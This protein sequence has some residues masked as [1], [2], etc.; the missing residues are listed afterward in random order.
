M[1]HDRAHVD[2]ASRTLL[3]HDAR[4]FLGYQKAGGQVG[5]NHLLPFLACQLQQGCANDDAGVIDHHV[6]AAVALHDFIECALDCRLVGHVKCQRVGVGA[7]IPELCCEIVNL[8][9][10]VGQHQAGTGSSKAASQARANTASS[11]GDQ[12]NLARQ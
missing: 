11:A 6:N 8:V 12:Y 10:Q 7:S 1:V 5:V 9:I 3:D 4:G 2:D